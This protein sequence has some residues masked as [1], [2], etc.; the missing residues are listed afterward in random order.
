MEIWETIIA[1]LYRPSS[2]H[3]KTYAEA[4]LD[5]LLILSTMGLEPQQ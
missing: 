4:L 5:S 3:M 2:A 1:Q